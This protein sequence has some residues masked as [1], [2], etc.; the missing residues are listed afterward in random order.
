MVLRFNHLFVFLNDRRDRVLRRG[1][2]R[3]TSIINHP[4]N[5]PKLNHL[6]LYMTLPC[7][8]YLFL[9]IIHSLTLRLDVRQRAASFCLA[10]HRG[11]GHVRPRQNLHFN[12]TEALVPALIANESPQVVV[13]DVPALP[14]LV[15]IFVAVRADPVPV[16]D[17]T[18]APRAH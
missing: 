14:T 2:R 18:A 1:L 17:L 5:Q 11:V 3:N 9:R 12:L 8:L 10:S 15:C 16:L 4:P 13:V 7:C 6:L